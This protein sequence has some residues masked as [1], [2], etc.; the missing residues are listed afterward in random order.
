MTKVKMK[1]KNYIIIVIKTL[2]YMSICLGSE[3]S[4]KLQDTLVMIEEALDVALSKT[5]AGFDQ[6][7][8]EKVQTA[9]RLLGKTQV[10][11]SPKGN[12]WAGE[13]LKK[14]A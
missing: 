5:C 9:Y 8:Y 3:L 6:T 13:L 2:I 11:S 1:C 12:G 14:N 10:T 4:S 7:H